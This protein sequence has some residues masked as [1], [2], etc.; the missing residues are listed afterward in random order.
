MATFLFDKTV[1]GPVISRRLGVSLGINLLPNQSKLCSFDCIYC[2]CGWN[3]DPKKV[4]AILPSRTDVFQALQHKLEQMG[5]NGQLPDVITFAGNGEPT[6]HPNFAQII[7]DTITLRNQFAPYARIA[8]LS[9]STMLFK[10]SV[11]DALK[12]VDDN[13]LKLDSAISQTI[14]TMNIP[15]GKFNLQ[16][17]V[18]Q[19]CAFNGK[20]IIQTMF[21]RGEHNGVKFDNTTE[22]EVTEWINLIATI[23]PEKVM[24]YTIARDTPSQN[25]QK[26]SL[27]EL[28]NIAIKLTEKLGIPVD[29]SA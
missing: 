1:F 22:H 17:L 7:D 18:D 3:P 4:K 11:V 6:I 14:Q 21:L 13:I 16:K 25:L 8:V 5:E 20:L 10:T 27:T 9:N 26:I 12:K 28:N 23:K 29:V 15:V 19:L 24:I 2:E